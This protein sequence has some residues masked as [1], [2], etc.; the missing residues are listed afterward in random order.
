LYVR[1]V[2]LGR[3]VALRGDSPSYFGCC[4]MM[5]FKR[6]CILRAMPSINCGEGLFFRAW[7]HLQPLFPAHAPYI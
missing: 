3:G 2:D 7:A 1:D 6:C 4:W 5:S